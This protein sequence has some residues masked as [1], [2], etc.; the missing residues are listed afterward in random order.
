MAVAFLR[1][2]VGD[3]RRFTDP[4][5]CNETSPTVVAIGNETRCEAPGFEGPRLRSPRLGAVGG[6][7][8]A[9]AESDF[10]AVYRWRVIAP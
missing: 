3:T 4:E 5:A 8:Q 2:T 10:T 7:A 6:S 9:N 1:I